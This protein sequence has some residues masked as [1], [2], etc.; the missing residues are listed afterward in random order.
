MGNGK[1]LKLCPALKEAIGVK[2][3][4][5][6]SIYAQIVTGLVES[7][8]NADG[9]TSLLWAL[10]RFFWSMTR[11]FFHLFCQVEPLAAQFFKNFPKAALESYR[12]AVA[13]LEAS[14]YGR[15]FGECHTANA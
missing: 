9:W 3:V 1:S 2:V 12:V 10:P 8:C 5:N 4:P 14:G 7:Y 13:I 6:N 11:P 15:C